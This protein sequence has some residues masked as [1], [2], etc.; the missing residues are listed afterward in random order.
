M[1]KTF[2]INISGEPFIIDEDAYTLLND[3]LQTLS[4]VF[5][6][7]P[8]GAQI[9]QD[10]ELRFAEIFSEEMELNKKVVTIEMVRDVI[11]RIGDPQQFGADPK[12]SESISESIGPDGVENIE[13][14]ETTTPPPFDPEGSIKKRLFRDPYEKILGGVCSGLAHY[15][16]IDPVYVRIIA[17]VLG[18]L[19]FSTLFWVYLILW[20]IIPAAKTPFQRMQMYGESATI[21]NIGQSVNSFFNRRSHS[22]RTD[23]LSPSHDTASWRFNHVLMILTKVVMVGLSLIALPILLAMVALFTVDLFLLFTLPF[24]NAFSAEFFAN[25]GFVN[26]PFS[27]ASVIFTQCCILSA[28]LIIAIPAFALIWCTFSLFSKNLTMKRGWIVT[29]CVSWVIGVMMMIGAFIFSLFNPELSWNRHNARTLIEM[30]MD[31]DDDVTDDNDFQITIQADS[32]SANGLQHSDEM[33]EQADSLKAS[34]IAFAD[35]A[36]SQAAQEIR[37]AQQD[38]RKSRQP[39]PSNQPNH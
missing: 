1:K 19:S 11:E 6:G 5:A 17:A 28:I 23:N 7:T 2:N 35:S 32:I 38:I 39:A 24:D 3:Y 37:Q 12:I 22:W 27:T 15:L 29:L 18:F 4:Q 26:S 20:I 25:F 30:A 14:N 13:I 9:E 10:I 34:A 16:G 33:Q 21:K 31:D 36:L 8:D